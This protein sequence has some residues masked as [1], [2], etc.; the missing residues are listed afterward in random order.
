MQWELKWDS[1]LVHNEIDLIS[2]VVQTSVKKGSLSWTGSG[3]NGYI[4]VK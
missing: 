4:K 1:D 3:G 2:F